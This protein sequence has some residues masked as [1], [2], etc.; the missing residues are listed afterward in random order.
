MPW[1]KVLVD[2]EDLERFHQEG[3]RTIK[4]VEA[5]R[6]AHAQLLES[7]SRVFLLGEGIDD[8]G[9]VFGSTKGLAQEF[10]SSRVMDIPIAENGMTGVAV[11][12]ATAGMRPIFIHMRMDFLPMCMDQLINHAAK[13]H[14][15]T[16]GSVR[17]PLVV[18]SIIGR[19]WGSA[20]QHSQG[21]HGLFL[22][23]PGL[24]IALPATPYD[25]K[26]MLIAAVE[27]ENPVLV[28]EHRWLYNTIGFV[29]EGLYSVPLGQALIRNPGTDVTVVALS[30]MVLE[31]LKAAR[32]LEQEGVSVEVV[33][34]RTIAP[35]DADTIL[36]SL[37]K[38][39]RLVVA[40]V[41][42]RT[43]GACAEIGCL[44]AER[45]PLALKAPLKRVAFPDAPTP[46]S[47]VLEQAYY[48]G[49]EAIKQAVRET[50]A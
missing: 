23:V 4:Y 34:P 29:P 21:L 40:D 1:T 33:D 37:S 5:L 35:L 10:G 9:G 47:P 24:R 31:A 14:Y 15:M 22:H 45:I 17:V 30:Y 44:V 12:A 20:G 26:G 42:S 16:G 3:K 43:G 41:A 25:A 46:A 19:G 6:E 32:D 49:A 28:C 7:D 38:T 27:D 11:G 39:G 2:Q 18:R 36:E 50:L 13:W 48:P 8:P